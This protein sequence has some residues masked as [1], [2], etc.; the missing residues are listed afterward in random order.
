MDPTHIAAF[1][2]STTNVFT[3]ML[4]LPVTTGDPAVKRGNSS[5]HDVSGIIGVSGQVSGSIVLSFPSDVATNI[6]SLLIGSEV[7]ADSEDF[8]DAIGEICNMVSGNAKAIFAKDGGVSISV[9]SVV[10]GQNHIVSS[11]SGSPTIQIP[12]QT[13]CGDFIVEITLRASATTETTDASQ[14]SAAA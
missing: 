12:C 8:A 6:A 4:Q 7:A 3:T 2:S 5:P 11:Q 10:I 13:D 9:P 14:A 1:I